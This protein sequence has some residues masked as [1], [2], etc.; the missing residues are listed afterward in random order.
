[1]KTTIEKRI[2]ADKTDTLIT[3]FSSRCLNEHTSFSS[4]IYK[5]IFQNFPYDTLDVIG[6]VSIAKKDVPHDGCTGVVGLGM[7]DSQ[8]NF[9]YTIK[10][11]YISINMYVDNDGDINYHE[12]VSIPG[13]SIKIPKLA[14]E[15]IE[16]F[17]RVFKE[18]TH[19][20]VL[21]NHY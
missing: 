7:S 11:Y 17:R 19:I 20:R 12:Y 14:K 10:G 18:N 16:N 15:T 6:H 13:E 2:H 3:G 1:M 4:I 21:E 5:G 8:I 9:E